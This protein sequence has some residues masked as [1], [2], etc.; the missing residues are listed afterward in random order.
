MVRAN[1]K[2]LSKIVSNL[3]ETILELNSTEALI[4]T[5]VVTSIELKQDIDEEERIKLIKKINSTI[6]SAFRGHILNLFTSVEEYLAYSLKESGIS[7]NNKTLTECLSR[8]LFANGITTKF[9]S[10]H[11]SSLKYRNNMAHRYN[12]PTTEELIAWWKINKQYYEDFMEFIEDKYKKELG[13][14]KNM[15][16][17]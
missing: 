1:N 16:C 8:C 12:E 7:V 11:R 13:N 6:K 15:K 14:T 4:D 9:E 17:F 5:V 10:T 3:S 2:R